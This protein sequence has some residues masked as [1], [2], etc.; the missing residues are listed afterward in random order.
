MINTVQLAERKSRSGL[1]IEVLT[2]KLEIPKKKLYVARAMFYVGFVVTLIFCF[3][4]YAIK[5]IG[6]GV[7][8]WLAFLAITFIGQYWI[9]SLYRCPKCESKLLYSSDRRKMGFESNCPEYCP[10][11]GER[12]VVKIIDEE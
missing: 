5:P 3:L 12:I 4:M 2:M 7:V 11:C 9:I 10:H 1:Q 8:V 6:V